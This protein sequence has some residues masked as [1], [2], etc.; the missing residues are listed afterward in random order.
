MDEGRFL[1]EEQSTPSADY[2][3]AP[4][5]EMR[6]KTFFMKVGENAGGFAASK[7]N[8]M[9][10]SDA[11]LTLVGEIIHGD[12]EYWRNLLT[13]QH[14]KGP[15]QSR[16]ARHISQ[17]DHPLTFNIMDPSTETIS[18][19]MK[20]GAVCI[21]RQRHR[22]SRLPASTA[23]PPSYP[24]YSPKL[25]HGQGSMPDCTPTVFLRT[26]ADLTWKSAKNEFIHSWSA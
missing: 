17:Y 10:D 14:E 22:R 7:A 8:L 23:N 3:A 12:S 24:K 11:L 2:S 1:G 4:A 15:F 16:C 26:E 20:C 13:K 5:A 21:R 18:N 6:W 19:R 25:C 9:R